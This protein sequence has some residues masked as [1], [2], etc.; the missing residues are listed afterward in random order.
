[1]SNKNIGTAIAVGLCGLGV[2]FV[3]VKLNNP[4]CLWALILV[5]CIARGMSSDN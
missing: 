5:A 4:H 2:C 3:A 1:M